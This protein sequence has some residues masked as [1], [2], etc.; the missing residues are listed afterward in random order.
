MGTA[1]KV[2]APIRVQKCVGNKLVV[3]E[4]E[5]YATL[6]S[7]ATMKYTDTEPV[8]ENVDPLD[9]VYMRR[10]RIHNTTEHVLHLSMVDVVFVDPA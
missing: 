5:K 9:N 7:G 4:V 8:F 3:T 10:V 6:P 2:I 1:E